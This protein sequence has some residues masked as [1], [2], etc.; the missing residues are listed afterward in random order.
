VTQAS[1]LPI[2]NCSP[3]I[4]LNAL[5]WAC[6]T[7]FRTLIGSLDKADQ[8]FSGCDDRWQIMDKRMQLKFP[9]SGDELMGWRA[10]V[11]QLTFLGTP[12]TITWS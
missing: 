11:A 10:G 6:F 2:Y 5:T 12:A 9:V 3:R 7:S 8:G 1:I 4:H